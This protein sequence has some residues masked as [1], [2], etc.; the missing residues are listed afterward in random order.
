LKT[1]LLSSIPIEEKIE[2]RR[3]RRGEERSFQLGEGRRGEKFS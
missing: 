1:S 3:G 2:E